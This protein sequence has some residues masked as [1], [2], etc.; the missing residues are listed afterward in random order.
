MNK[1]QAERLARAIEQHAC[2]RVQVIANAVGLLRELRELPR[3]P[4]GK[5]DPLASMRSSAWLLIVRHAGIR[6]PILYGWS[7]DEALFDAVWAALARH[8]LYGLGADDGHLAY[9]APACD[10]D[11][12]SP[13]WRCPIHDGLNDATEAV[14]EMAE[15]EAA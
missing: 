9:R 10:A 6:R 4:T 5:R 12:A 1:R 14:A 2:L 7:G 15:L 8:D 13:R 11:E 3:K